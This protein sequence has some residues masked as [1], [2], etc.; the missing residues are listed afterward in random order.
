MMN[1]YGMMG[2]GYMGLGWLFQV[3]ILVL[4]FLIVWW[5]LKSSSSFGFKV[6]DESAV[7]ILKKR[8]A[9]GDI[10]QKE[11]ESLKKEIEKE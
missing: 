7:D 11:Y 8:L 10:S 9:S 4:F 1:G 5:I 3:F 6:G 2:Y